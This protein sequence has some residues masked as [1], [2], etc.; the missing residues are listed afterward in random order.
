MCGQAEDSA[1]AQ[2]Q[3]AIHLRRWRS[4]REGGTCGASV[5]S[6]APPVAETGPLWWGPQVSCPELVRCCGMAGTSRPPP[7]RGRWVSPGRAPRRNSASGSWYPVRSTGVVLRPSRSPEHR[8]WSHLA[9]ACLP[10]GA[11]QAGGSA[12]RTPLAP[13]RGESGCWRLTVQ[14]QPCHQLPRGSRQVTAYTA[15]ERRTDSECSCEP[16]SWGPS[17]ASSLPGVGR[18]KLAGTLPLRQPGPGSPRR[19]LSSCCPSRIH[20]LTGAFPAG[21]EVGTR[22]CSYRASKLVICPVTCSP[23]GH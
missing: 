9:P 7:A 16:Q 13:C 10:S 14:A 4:C 12:L 23:R 22:S 3:G 21:Q 18:W 15:W 17:R 19:A 8:P 1:S 2:S 11:G 6:V 20:A 5:L